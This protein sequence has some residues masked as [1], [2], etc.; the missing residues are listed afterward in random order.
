MEATNNYETAGLK[1]L[2]NKNYE[3]ALTNFDKSINASKSNQGA[4]IGRSRAELYLKKYKNAVIDLNSAI[5]LNKNYSSG[6][7]YD[8]SV[9]YLSRGW[10][11]Y[12]SGEYQEALH[13][14]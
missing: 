6:Y 13:M 12:Y 3:E 4:Y 10:A 2:G 11:N 9:L 5:K 1:N 7:G 8:L 14:A